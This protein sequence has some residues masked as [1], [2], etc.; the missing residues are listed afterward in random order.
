M[1]IWGKDIA[2]TSITTS[3]IE[4]LERDRLKYELEK[5]KLEAEYKA[6]MG[7]I[8]SAHS[9]GLGGLMGTTVGIGTPYTSPPPTS[10]GGFV[11]GGPATWPTYTEEYNDVAKGLHKNYMELTQMFN[12]LKCAVESGNSEWVSKVI[13]R[14]V[15]HELIK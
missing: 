6:H 10:P 13:A 5:A 8:A 4:E 9:S 12:E 2:P 7:K 15:E 11:G 14:I 3:R 1:A